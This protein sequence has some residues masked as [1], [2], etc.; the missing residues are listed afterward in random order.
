MTA[1]LGDDQ[2]GRTHLFPIDSASNQKGF[3]SGAYDYFNDLKVAAQ[4]PWCGSSTSTRS[5]RSR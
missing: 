1:F 5:S 4:V 2:D 3:S